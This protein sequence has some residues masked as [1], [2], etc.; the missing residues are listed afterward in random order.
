VKNEN[1]GAQS[2][3]VRSNF[4]FSLFIFHFSFLFFN[5]LVQ[6]KVC[7]TS[8][9]HVKTKDLLDLAGDPRFISGIYNYCDRWCERCSFTSRCL[10]YA[11]EQADAGDDEANDINN[12]AFWDKLKSVFEQTREMITLMAKE[13]GIDLDSLDLAEAGERERKRREKTRSSELSRSGEQY[14]KEVNQWFEREYP[15]IEQA[16]NAGKGDLPLVDFDLQEKSERVNDAIEVIRWYQ[17]QIAVKIMR[18]LMRDDEDEEDELEGVQQKDS[19]GSIKVALIGMD[20]S[21][22]AWG[23]LQEELPASAGAI[24]PLLVRLERLRRK[25]ERTFPDAR[26]FI[27]P[28]FDEAPDSFIS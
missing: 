16:L 7:A 3:F 11:Q 4:H 17:F 21:I 9:A 20:R 22:G 1:C 18:G 5:G 2:D 10:L 13:R 8:E 26:S 19:D 6:T 23:R 27:R 14:A 12:E 15:K 24:L 25:T 28:G